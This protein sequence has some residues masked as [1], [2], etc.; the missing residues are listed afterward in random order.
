MNIITTLVG[1]NFR[2]AEARDLVKELE[3]GDTVELRGDF[4]NPYDSNAVAVYIDDQHCGF[5]AA[6]DNGPLAA[7]IRNGAQLDAEVVAF[8]TSLKPVLEL[9][10]DEVTA[11][12]DDYAE[13]LR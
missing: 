5:I 6:K 3:I 4:D 7:A 12:D 10:L 11:L 8:E 2:P 9:D 1:A 13:D